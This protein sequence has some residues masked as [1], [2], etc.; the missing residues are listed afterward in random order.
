MAVREVE[1]N[2]PGKFK[3]EPF[4]YY[5]IKNFEVVPNIVEASFST[6]MGWAMVRFEGKEKE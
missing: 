1:L 5:L 2:I 6:D 3:E 4:F